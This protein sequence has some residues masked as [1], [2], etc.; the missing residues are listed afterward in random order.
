MDSLEKPDKD[1]LLPQFARFEMGSKTGP[2]VS[3]TTTTKEGILTTRHSEILIP[4]D[5]IQVIWEGELDEVKVYRITR[6]EW[7][8][9][10]VGFHIFRMEEDKMIFVGGVALGSFSAAKQDLIARILYT[11]LTEEKEV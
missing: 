9:G 8:D 6:A 5:L 1:S 4:S 10:D 2:W 3:Q 11:V 7:S